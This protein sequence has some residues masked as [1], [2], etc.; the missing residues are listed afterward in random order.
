MPGK[1]KLSSGAQGS[2]SLSTP[3]AMSIVSTSWYRSN[4]ALHAGSCLVSVLDRITRWVQYGSA[5]AS[6]RRVLNTSCQQS[7]GTENDDVE[8]IF[9]PQRSAKFFD[10]AQCSMRVTASVFPHPGPPLTK[11]IPH[12]PAAGD[13]WA[14]SARCSSALTGQP[15]QDRSCDWTWPSRCFARGSIL[16]V[17]RKTSTCLD[18]PFTGIE[19]SGSKSRYDREASCVAASTRTVPGEVLAMSRAD[20][21]TVSPSTV[22]SLRSALPTTPHQQV[23]VATPACPTRPSSCRVSQSRVAASTARIGSSA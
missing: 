5:L 11:T 10:L 4:E 6:S 7:R 22:Y 16:P 15:C 14:S 17:K 2:N 23:P 20:R 8:F 21:L 13:S 18:L 12:V 19:P 1:T 3:A 9:W